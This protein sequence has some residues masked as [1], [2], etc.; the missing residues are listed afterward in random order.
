MRTMTL[1]TASMIL[2]FLLYFPKGGVSAEQVSHQGMMVDDDGNPNNCI[3][4]HDGLIASEVHS[5]TV[6]CG[7]GGSHSISREYPPRSKESG[8]ASV[9]SLREKGIRLYNGKVSCASCHDLKKT[10]EYHLVMDNSGS[11]LCFSCHII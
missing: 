5:C 4:C 9:E 10:T 11:D 8:Y 2:V 1:I 3:V 6:E 7:F